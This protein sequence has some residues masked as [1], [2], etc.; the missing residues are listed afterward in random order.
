MARYFINEKSKDDEDNIEKNSIQSDEDTE[1]EMANFNNNN[2]NGNNNNME[3][4]DIPDDMSDVDELEAN[5]ERLL[6]YDED[7]FAE[8][9]EFR[10]PDGYNI[11]NPDVKIKTY[12]TKD[13][14]C[15]SAGCDGTGHVTGLYSHHRSLSGCPRKDR[16]ST[17][18][19]MFCV[20][21]KLASFM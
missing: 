21:F 1:I 8:D 6:E 13:S 4:E 7:E 16:A 3:N 14:K 12:P 2:N 19:S 15:P 5:R 10:L 17:L 18:Q 11:N 9:A 20:F